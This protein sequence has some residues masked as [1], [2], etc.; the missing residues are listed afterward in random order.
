MRAWG[1]EK[2]A[3]GVLVL[4]LAAGGI[5]GCDKPHKA[6]VGSLREWI[7]GEWSR[8]DDPALWVFNESG[9]ML[10]S[11]RVPIGGSYS[12]EEPDQV[13]ILIGG[14][15]AYTAS[16][17]LGVALDEAKN[18]TLHLEVKDDEMRPVGI[19]SSTVFRKR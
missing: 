3:A 6:R 5:S 12:V 16:K 11:G 15:G 18:L 10:T 2:M 13:T 9:E 4:M 17:M 1:S 7:V 8:S 14:A 19:V